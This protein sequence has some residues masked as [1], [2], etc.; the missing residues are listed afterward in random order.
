M[1]YADSYMTKD[2]FEAMFDLSL[3]KEMRA[4]YDCEKAFPHV[5]QKVNKA[6]RAGSK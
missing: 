5:Y 4:K 6:A 2:E 1:M 3:Y